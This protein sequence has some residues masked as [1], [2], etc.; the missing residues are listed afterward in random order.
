MIA[1]IFQVLCAL[2][3]LVILSVIGF[4]V[5]NMEFIKSGLASKAIKKRTDIFTGIKD[6][7]YTNEIEYNTEDT[8]IPMYRD[9]MPSYNQRGGAEFSYNFWVRQSNTLFGN[10][11]DYNNDTIKTD[12]G[13]TNKEVILFV[14]GVNKAY[15]YDNI[16]KEPKTDVMVKCP[17]VKLERMGNYLTL[18]VNTVQ[19]VD[20]IKEA[21]KNTCK[22]GDKSWSAMNRWKLSVGGLRTNPRFNENWFMVTVVIQDTLATDS[23]PMRNKV[24]ARIFINGTMELDQYLDGTIG[25]EGISNPTVLKQNNGNLYVLPQ[26][27]TTSGKTLLPTDPEKLMMADMSYF[28][29]ALNGQDAKG[30]FSK[31]LTKR[32]ADGANINLEK[33]SLFTISTESKTPQLTPL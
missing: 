5:Y 14:K 7:K 6:A 16:C 21:S 19:A 33:E 17:L 15:T 18:E 1:V 23:L 11:T 10:Y 9:I 3:I 13:L 30:L 27:A 32:S 31:G 26:V 8:T 20:P 2:I 24:R 28:N 22:E 25:E 4:A 12:D 29:Y